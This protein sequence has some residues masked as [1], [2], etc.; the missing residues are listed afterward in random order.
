[1]VYLQMPDAGGRQIFPLAGRP[2]KDGEPAERHRQFVAALQD[3]C[4][5]LEGEQGQ[6]SGSK[7]S[8]GRF[9]D[10]IFWWFC[11]NFRRC[12][13]GNHLTETIEWVCP[14]MEQSYLI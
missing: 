7:I 3:G 2:P 5:G 12:R 4:T 1:M 9:W 8:F 11:L 10:P 6:D 13:N 14:E